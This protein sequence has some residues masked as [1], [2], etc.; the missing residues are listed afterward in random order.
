MTQLNAARTMTLISI[1][2]VLF[3]V[4]SFALKKKEPPTKT[5][6]AQV[7]DKANQSM[8]G[9]KVFVRNVSKDTTSVLVSDD[10]GMVSIY[11]LDPKIDF[12]VHAEFGELASKKK[13][14]SAFLNRMDNLLVFVLSERKASSSASAPA[15]SNRIEVQ[16]DCADEFKLSADW[17]A[18]VEKTGKSPVVILVHGFGEDRHSWDPFIQ[19]YLLPKGFGVLNIDLRGH[20]RS[21]SKGN[22]QVQA[23]QS[24]IADPRQFPVDMDAAVKWLKSKEGIDVNRIACIGTELGADLAYFASGKFEEIR[25]AVAVSC[26]AE[27]AQLWTKGISNFQP[28]SILYVVAQGDQSGLES[29]HEL[30]RL[31]GF[32]VNLKVVE[33]SNLRGSNLI[34]GNSEVSQI[35][36]DWLQKSI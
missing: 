22:D 5:I 28:H 2:L 35:I 14:V 15:G 31:T 13:T 19:S 24:W 11:G 7:V 27:L 18:P 16:L 30:E 1:L 9:A 20:G 36:L 8:P 3:G 17:Y 25:T 33:S 6:R 34:R 10:N 26:S 12:E 29:A 32:P 21:I 23:Q 4:D